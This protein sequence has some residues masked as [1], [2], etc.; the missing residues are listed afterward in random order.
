MLT[1]GFGDIVPS[2]YHEAIWVIFIEIISCIA[3]SYN[4]SCL[5]NLIGSIRAQGEMVSKNH[6]IF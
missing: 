2:N 5:G 3:F 4:I 6:K 1:V